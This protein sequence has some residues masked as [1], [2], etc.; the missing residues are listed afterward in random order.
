MADSAVFFKDYGDYLY[1]I[2]T[3]YFGPNPYDDCSNLVLVKK[4]YSLYQDNA[5]YL[6]LPGQIYFSLNDA[7]WYI[8]SDGVYVWDFE[9]EHFYQV[10]PNGQN[11]QV[12]SSS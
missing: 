2:E 9:W 4:A 1:I 6:G 7:D 10:S 12:I 5:E 11:H 8:K 3:G